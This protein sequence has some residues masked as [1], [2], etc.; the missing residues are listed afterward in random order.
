MQYLDDLLLNL[1]NDSVIFIVPI[2]QR[3][4][5][6]E[7]IPSLLGPSRRLLLPYLFHELVVGLLFILGREVA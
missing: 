3:F 7:N 6:L 1:E 2:P 4:V 5:P